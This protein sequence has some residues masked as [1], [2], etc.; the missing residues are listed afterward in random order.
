MPFSRPI[1][2]RRA[3]YAL[4]IAAAM[5]HATGEAIAETISDTETLS[6]DR[7]IA[8]LTLKP[9]G[10][11]DLQD[12][13]LT[14]RDDSTIETPLGSA[15]TITGAGNLIVGDTT[16]AATLLIEG[17]TDFTGTTSIS[18]QATVTLD[19][20][21][22]LRGSSAI[23][24]ES[25]GR[26]INKGS[27]AEVDAVDLESGGTLDLEET[28]F[29]GSDGGT[30]ILAGTLDSQDSSNGLVI[31]GDTSISGQNG[32][33]GGSV[34]IRDDAELTLTATGAIGAP[35]DPNFS[36][37]AVEPGSNLVLQ[38]ANA[39]DPTRKLTV[40]SMETKNSMLTFDGASL[41]VE[42]DQTVAELTTQAE[43]TVTLA[44][45]KTLTVN[46]AAE[47]D[48]GYLSG[49]ITGA[50]NLSFSGDGELY[51]TPN[52]EFGLA[53]GGTT[54]FTGT[55]TVDGGGTLYLGGQDALGGSSSLILE[56]GSTVI[57]QNATN[58]LNTSIDVTLDN[59]GTGTTTLNLKASQTIE[60][61]ITGDGVLQV[62]GG[63]TTIG[64]T[65]KVETGLTAGD[66][67]TLVNNGTIT[68]DEES[69]AA[70][71]DGDDDATADDLT[72]TNTGTIAATGTSTG[73]NG[74]FL[75]D[76]DRANI[77]NSGTIEA[78]GS[79]GIHLKLSD[80]ATI[81]N[82]GD[83][84]A[85][86]NNGIFIEESTNASIDNSGKIE[87]GDNDGIDLQDSEN[88]KVV[89][90]GTIEAKNDNGILL[91]GSKGV[92]IQNT[93]TIN[94]GDDDALEGDSS[95]RLS[96]T[97]SGTISAADNNAVYLKNSAN[98][99]IVNDGIIS[100]TDQDGIDLGD[101][102]N[103]SVVNNG[104]ISAGSNTGIRLDDST[105]ARIT[106][107]GAIE[108]I[109]NNGILFQGS[110]GAYIENTG[111]IS[112]KRGAIDAADTNT[113]TNATIVNSGTFTSEGNTVALQDDSVLRNSGTIEATEAGENA[114]YAR[115]TGT[116]VTLEAGSTI[117]GDIETVGAGNTLRINVG[118]A[119]S[120]MYETSGDWT[121]E[122]LD[123]RP[124]VEG[125]VMT[126]GIGNLETADELMHRRAMDL[127]DSLARLEHQDLT[128]TGIPV[129]VD[130]YTGEE[131]RSIDANGNDDAS[132][133]SDYTLETTGLTLGTQIGRAER[134]ITLF[135]A[136]T[137]DDLDI[138]N[139]THRI[140]AEGV[141]IGAA[142][143]S[144][145]S[146]G[147]IAFGGRVAVGRHDYE[148]DREILVNTIGSNGMTRQE[149]DWQ[150]DVWEIAVDARYRRSLDEQ[151]TLTFTPELGI[152][153]E[154]VEAYRESA[155]LQWDKRE[156]TQGRVSLDAALDYLANERTQLGAALTVWHRDVMDGEEADYTLGGDQVA[157][158]DPVH[159]DQGISARLGL[160]RKLTQ[161]IALNATAAG[162]WTAE[163]TDGW[164]LGLSVTGRY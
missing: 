11:L 118:S 47:T 13:T 157:Y 72:I 80:S 156:I 137:D 129:L 21:E 143:S 10:L 114:I 82:S 133:R 105:D 121:L 154:R 86:N 87:A 128:G 66:A 94:A 106:N 117:I 37:I 163:D 18:D 42:A 44:A 68:S 123:G 34:Q 90:S 60:G 147:N 89:N 164:T 142:S 30:S 55:T 19:D 57:A 78:N 3:T 58:A 161:S 24:I 46:T 95:E 8:H 48:E 152:Q 2:G 115:G 126:T 84:I 113:V 112:A 71:L 15:S 50:G 45:G 4:M 103:A 36:D 138:D 28:L 64:D 59:T 79:T 101:S 61:E 131:D 56:N 49:N 104:T 153:Q 135:A 92:V 116:V 53:M 67:I 65:G 52:T 162:H 12:N 9:G 32:D 81:L 100:A 16:A 158:T 7:E 70:T 69:V 120:I 17:K 20:S 108:V 73:N 14:L 151:L 134:P 33:F 109:G 40:E 29:I 26:L 35:D 125:S 62:T 88:A 38:A 146:L 136:Y 145:F 98:A 75:K 160:E 130:T 93:G 141:R 148:G 6:A 97:N 119:Q 159:D 41:S 5:T 54:D 110:S 51:I 155:D 127:R 107:N 63:T 140:K 83:I 99:N 91:K 122:S 27:G 74:L 23:T 149:A 43:S 31:K 76:S 25:G 139:D 77:N 22:G 132:T 39:I 150:S 85:G 96:L 111:T 144:L 102:S 124:V 1:A